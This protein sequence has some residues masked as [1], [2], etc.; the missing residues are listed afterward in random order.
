MGAIGAVPWRA[1][2]LSGLLALALGA[3]IYGFAADG[4]SFRRG[5]APPHPGLS[6]LPLTAQRAVS[7]TLGADDGAYS[8]RALEGELQASAPAQGLSTRFSRSG[9]LVSSGTTRVGF[10]LSA[11][12]YGSSPQALER[13]SPHARGNRVSYARAG[14]SEWYAN[15][16]LGLEQGFTLQRP[17][18][19][20]VTRALTL[21]LS[22][23]GNARA[24]VGSGAQSVTL[25]HSGGPT[26]RYTGLSVIDARGHTL[27]S[28]LE[29]RGASLLLRVDARGAL[30]PLRIDPFIQ[31][32]EKLTGSGES[33]K[34]FFGYGVALSSDGNT[35]LIGGY[36]NN[37]KV[38]AAWV[39]TRS[40][41]TWSQQGEKLTGSGESGKGSFGLSVAL[42]ADGNT[43]L[44]GGPEDNGAV[45][46]AWVFTR[47]G[48]T[49]AQQG[50]KLTGS[51]ES[52]Q[53]DFAVS[54]ALSGDGNTALVGGPEDN[55]DVG[56]AWVFTHSES[57]WT[58]QG[59]KLTGSG[60]SG[61][62]F[63]GFSVALS[64]DGNT[65]VIGVPQDATIGAASVFTRSESTWTQQGEKLTGSG[66][67]GKGLFGISVALSSDG[68]TAL[69]GG[70][71]DNAAAGAAW[72]FTSAGSTWSQQGKKLTGS[73]ERGKGRFGASVALSGDGNT[74]LIGGFGDHNLVGAAW[75]FTRSGSTWSQ[76]GNKLT[77]SGELGKG[78][79]GESV[80]LSGDVNTAL[81]GG[82]KDNS[83]KGATWVFV[84]SPAITSLNPNT[85]PVTGGTTVTITGTNFGGV[86]AVTFGSTSAM[87][88]TVNSES[89]ITAVS[90]A[91]TPGTVN[92]TVT[93]PA[94]ASAISPADRFEFVV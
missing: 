46:A 68:T 37:A 8:V 81:I 61:A 34:G 24:A 76:Q 54:V 3:A 22:L 60:E 26:L 44:I 90:P 43:A 49:W 17:R 85:G 15:G 5:A 40:G 66:E 94:G 72:V 19:G 38:G 45:G 69:I 87:S 9:V 56:A 48:S 91:E 14:L 80:A 4:S 27:R 29:L 11:L 42:S 64:G 18:V 7:A 51:G 67:T 25:S 65:A 33:G 75:V 47:S 21:S 92:V 53:G 16:P 88:F 78:R 57:T 30:Y 74:A 12:G 59:E 2:V 10:S 23:S 1:L 73:G 28:W 77:G 86:T 39:F 84:N 41:T 79:F 6:S 36:A 63:F 20:Q 93:T 71:A 55:A 62:G 83:G 32:G 13:V 82:L 35:A 52:G 58:Q 89:S 50:E 70:Y 31:Q